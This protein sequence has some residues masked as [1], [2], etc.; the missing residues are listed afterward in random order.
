M[1]MPVLDNF[2]RT[3]ETTVRRS[4][5]AESAGDLRRLINGIHDIPPSDLALI[6]I[7]LEGLY[8]TQGQI[9]VR[10]LAK[11][12]NLSLR[13]F[14]RRFKQ[15]AGL[16]PKTLGRLIRFEFTRDRLLRDPLRPLAHLPSDFGYTDQ[17]HFIRDFKTLAGWT[18]G[19]FIA[20][21]SKRS[22]TTFFYT[23]DPRPRYDVL[24]HK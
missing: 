15:L 10:E 3:I 8:D 2:T 19:E 21:A 20:A 18:P 17:S 5:Y 9:P 12:S 13:Q 14:E 7:S 23:P 1:P 11:G 6:Q 4:R 22:K 16:S 24:I